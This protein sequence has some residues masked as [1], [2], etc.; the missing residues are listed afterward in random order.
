MPSWACCCHLR[1]P[2]PSNIMMLA[3]LVRFPLIFISGIFV[4]LAEMTGTARTITMFS[5]L[6][7]LVDG[8]DH[9]LGNE[10]AIPLVLDLLM[11]FTAAFLLAANYMLKRKSLMG[12]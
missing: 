6:T 12:L 2:V 7:Y 3:A 4:P 5:P 9:A 10:G 1:G 8:F 11:A